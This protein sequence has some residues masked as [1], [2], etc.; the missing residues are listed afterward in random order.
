MKKQKSLK[1]LKKKWKK[2]QQLKQV[3][4]LKKNWKKLKKMFNKKNRKIMVKKTK[5]LMAKLPIRFQELKKS[6][7]LKKKL[8]SYVIAEKVFKYWSDK[9]SSTA[10]LNHV[11]TDGEF[12]SGVMIDLIRNTL[13]VA[14]GFNICE[15]MS[16]KIAEYVNVPAVHLA[17]EY[18]VTD[19]LSNII[20]EFVTTF[21]YDFRT[22]ADKENCQVIS[23]KYK[24]PV[25]N[26]LGA[27][28]KDDYEEEELTAMFVELNDN[29]NA[30]TNAFDMSYNLWLEY[31][32]ISFIG[33]A[34]RVP[35]I[36]NISANNE[37][38][39]IISQISES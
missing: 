8:N 24:L 39:D 35:K 7:K 26:H 36:D 10:F 9:L 33:G 21:G 5:A 4:N 20:N 11:I 13:E 14:E 1:Q 19:V 25:F 12:D 27:E 29:P 22:Q 3:K 2:F 23:E 38:A 31:M 28:R 30:L 32:Y 37:V 15:M 16:S 34:D 6:V 18:L 17:N